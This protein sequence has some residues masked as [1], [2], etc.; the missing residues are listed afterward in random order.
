MRIVFDT[1]GE[2]GYVG[3][4]NWANFAVAAGDI[5]FSSPTYSVSEGGGA[6]RIT[7]TRMNGTAAAEAAL[8]TSSGVG[9]TG[10][11]IVPNV[12]LDQF[13]NVSGPLK[14]SF[15]GQSGLD[16]NAVLAAFTLNGDGEGCQPLR[17]EESDAGA[18][19][20]KAQCRATG[21]TGCHA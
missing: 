16:T 14:S 10:I 21:A 3:N 20:Q 2:S 7:V 15:Q 17:H 4:L 13:G 6:I 19:G 11:A 8:D 9:P 1:A 18:G 12:K 5:Q